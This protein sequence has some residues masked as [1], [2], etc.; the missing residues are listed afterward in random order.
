MERKNS[1]AL[2]G[3]TRILNVS[4]MSKTVL[5]FPDRVVCIATGAPPLGRSGSGRD[6][7]CANGNGGGG[8]SAE[9]L[10]V[11]VSV[12]EAAGHQCRDVPS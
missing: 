1:T 5:M 2:L 12:S 3:N 8:R 7:G 6:M 11:S 10:G 4:G 9:T